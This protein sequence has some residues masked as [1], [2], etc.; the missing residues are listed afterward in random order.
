MSVMRLASTGG[1][2]SARADDLT[3]WPTLFHRSVDASLV[4]LLSLGAVM[5]LPGC[6]GSGAL[7]QGS[8][9]HR[10]GHATGRDIVDEVPKILGGHGYAIYNTRRT[11]DTIYFETNW[12]NRAP[13]DDEAEG[14]AEQ[15]RTRIIVRARRSSESFFTVRLEAQNEVMGVITGGDPTGTDW[16]TM[17]ATDAYRTYVRDLTNEITLAVD[18][19]RRRGATFGTASALRDGADSGAG[20]PA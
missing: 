19:G 5:L 9:G 2:C 10:V 4:G 13:F 14:G 17:P 1:R 8:V 7:R 15:A 20:R 12:R 16:S 3:G 18:A 11:D 6:A